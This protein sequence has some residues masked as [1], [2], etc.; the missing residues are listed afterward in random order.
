[1]K[2]TLLLLSLLL[3]AALAA[4]PKDAPKAP[5]KA[6][7]VPAASADAELDAAVRA[8]IEAFFLHVKAHQV[9][10]GFARLFEGSSLAADQPAL[11]STLV[12]NTLLL[13]EKCGKMESSSIVRVRSA[14]RALKEVTCVMNCQKRPMRWTMFVYFGEGRWQVLDAE[15]DLELHAFFDDSKPAAK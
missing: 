15:V 5:P 6:T 9:Q 7:P 14:G 8:R 11:L 12:K 3:P 10:D 4:P 13:I 1:M 2:L